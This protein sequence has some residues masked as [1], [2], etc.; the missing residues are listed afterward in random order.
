MYQYFFIPATDSISFHDTTFKPRPEDTGVKK[1][2]TYA[3]D[4]AKNSLKKLM[5][6]IGWKRFLK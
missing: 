3:K 6:R 5:V 1:M 4:F 2:I